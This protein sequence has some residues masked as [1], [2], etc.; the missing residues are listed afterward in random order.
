M[1]AL[2]S[3]VSGVGLGW[4]SRAVP[5]CTLRDFR[6]GDAYGGGRK[7]RIPL[8]GDAG[9]RRGA[10]LTVATPDLLRRCLWR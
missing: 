9:S 1:K 8:R 6:A 5:A 4:V 3:P 2:Q 10:G 7:D